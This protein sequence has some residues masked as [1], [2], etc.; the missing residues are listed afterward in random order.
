VQYCCFPA[1]VGLAR[2]AWAVAVPA[3][4]LGYR[5]LVWSSPVL[6]WAFWKY[7]NW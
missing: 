5:L 4:H 1:Q 3:A 6:I 2:A 7:I